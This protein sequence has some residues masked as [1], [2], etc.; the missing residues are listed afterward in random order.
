N[1]VVP[2]AA[3]QNSHAQESPADHGPAAR[4]VDPLF[5]RIAAERRAKG[6][7]ERHG[8]SGVAEV[9][10]RRMYVHLAVLQERREAV[11]VGKRD[12]VRYAS[13][14]FCSNEAER[15]G[16]EIIENQKE[17]LNTAENHANVGHQL[18]M[19]FA[20]CEE[21]DES[22]YGE[23]PAPEKQRALLPRPERGEFIPARQRAVAVFDD[24]SERKIILEEG[25][26]EASYRQRDQKENGHSGVASAL[27]KQRT[28][29]A[30]A[31]NA[32]DESVSGGEKRQNQGKGADNVH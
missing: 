2:V 26:D 25:D 16:N 9:A 22:P 8:E 15:A 19:F 13:G 28:T 27:D 14:A 6:K 31:D 1:F 12:D 20:I 5:A 18:R 32:A 23:Q 4:D 21:R 3:E 10:H 17:K 30:N 29:R 24:V 7:G 11:S